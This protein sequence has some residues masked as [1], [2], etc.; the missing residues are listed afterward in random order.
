MSL[1][2]DECLETVS[3]SELLYHWRFTA[4]HFVLAIRPLRLTTS[5]IIYQLKIW[6]YFP[7]VTSTLTRGCVCRLQLLLVLASAVILRSESRCLT[8]ETPSTSRARSPYLYPP[9]SGWS[10]YTLKHWV[11]DVRAKSK[12]LNDWRFTVDQFVL[13]KYSLRPMTRYF[14]QMN[15]CGNSLYATS[16]RTRRWGCLSCTCF[17]FC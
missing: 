5:N 2:A 13:A 12:L 14:F 4:N 10:Y 6:G 15:S 11:T 1:L 7:D 17:S 8:F 3:E 9:G 16:S